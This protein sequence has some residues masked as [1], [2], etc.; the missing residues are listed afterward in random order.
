MEKR[1]EFSWGGVIRSYGGWEKVKEMKKNKVS[2]RADDRILGKSE[3]IEN[4]LKK[5]DEEYKEKIVKNKKGL[6]IVKALIRLIPESCTK[7][8]KIGE[9]KGYLKYN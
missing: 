2:W 4:I 3:F 8:K 5:L 6:T 7:I 1:Q 9:K